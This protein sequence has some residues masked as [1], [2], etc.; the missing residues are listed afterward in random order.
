MS[1]RAV[2]VVGSGHCSEAESTLAYSV[3]KELAEAGIAVITGG[4]GGVMEAACHGAIEARGMTVGILPGRDPLEANAYVRVPI[5]TG[6]G[7]FRNFLVV[8]A[9][10]SVIAI[11]GEWGTLSEIAMA[12]KLG[13]RVVGLSS[14]E[15]KGPSPA[16]LT[17]QKA[18]TPEQ[19]VKFALASPPP[20][21]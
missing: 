12:M 7:E 4:L 17:I 9:A 14:W 21:L 1:W 19:A 6:L 16:A 11:G 8:S 5:P 3:G 20:S 15:L 18:E 10:E 2:A 13:K